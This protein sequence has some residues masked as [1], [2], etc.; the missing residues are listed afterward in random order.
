VLQ[1]RSAF[2]S[3]GF[4]LCDFRQPS[5]KA[6][7]YVKPGITD[8]AACSGLSAEILC[9]YTGGSLLP[10]SRLREPSRHRLA[11]HG[12]TDKTHDS[13]AAFSDRIAARKSAAPG[14]MSMPFANHRSVSRAVKTMI[15]HRSPLFFGRSRRHLPPMNQI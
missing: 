5:K 10:C 14:E 11:R 12:R 3:V 15:W 1:T 8:E 6:S 2:T 4:D 9:S 7:H 13:S